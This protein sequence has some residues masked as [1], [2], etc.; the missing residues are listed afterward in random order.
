MTIP[1]TPTGLKESTIH[2]RG[3]QRVLAA[4]G[5]KGGPESCRNIAS[6]KEAAELERQ[7]EVEREHYH[8]S[9]HPA[10]EKDLCEAQWPKTKKKARPPVG[11][12]I[13]ENPV[14]SFAKEPRS[15]EQ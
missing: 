6:G 14:A 10:S 11:V 3:G 4:E 15:D 8:E 13:D 9:K 12:P 7:T 1:S 5:S 2:S